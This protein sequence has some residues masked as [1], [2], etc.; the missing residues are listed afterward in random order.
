MLMSGIGRNAEG[1]EGPS[2]CGCMRHRAG[3]PTSSPIV[4]PFSQNRIRKPQIP[5]K[6]AA[7]LS[8]WTGT[9]Q[10]LVWRRGATR[11]TV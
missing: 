9:E 10:L 3:C 11:V 2:R 6:G 8:K 5:A 1:G 7:I 4:A